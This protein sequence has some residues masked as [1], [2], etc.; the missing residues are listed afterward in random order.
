MGDLRAGGR[1]AGEHFG[2]D[3]TTLRVREQAIHDLRI[4][5]ALIARVSEGGQRAMA[6]FEVR[7]GQIVEHQR[8]IGEMLGSQLRFDV[9]LEV[10]EPVHGLVQVV[11]VGA[12]Q[13]EEFSQ[14]AG[15][16]IEAESAGGCE[17]G[18]GL[19]DP[20]HD[21]GAN[22]IAL[23]GGSRREDTI[24]AERA[25]SAQHGGDMAV[26]QRASDPERGG[27]IGKGLAFED[28][29]ERVD[30][31]LRPIREI[32]EGAL[33]NLGAIAGG[34]AEE[35]GGRRIAIGDSLHVHGFMVAR[36]RRQAM[37]TIYIYMG[38]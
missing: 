18:G 1:V 17:F 11:F 21:H 8:A 31:R 32:G 29:S 36:M 6:A 23:P 34:L 37:R 12:G 20:C 2:S 13:M 38:T 35:A 16:G 10:N 19:D 4:A 24:Q 30:L 27:G 26:G 7:G 3:G 14:T 15:G 28:A 33:A 25:K 22:Q 5:G 9:G